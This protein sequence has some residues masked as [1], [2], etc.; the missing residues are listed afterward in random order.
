VR[1]AADGG[2]PEH[3]EQRADIADEQV[4]DHVRC[5]AAVERREVRADRNAEPED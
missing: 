1:G 2:Q 5:E 3:D 4:L